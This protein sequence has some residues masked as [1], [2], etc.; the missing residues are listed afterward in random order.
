MRNGLHGVFD[1]VVSAFA[2]TCYSCTYSGIVSLK[3]DISSG[4]AFKIERITHPLERRWLSGLREVSHLSTY[5]SMN[6]LSYRRACDGQLSFALK[7]PL[8]YHFCVTCG[9][10]DRLDT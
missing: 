1:Y 8:A 9:I 7:R 3:Q 10:G 2:G 6:V 4:S 5:T